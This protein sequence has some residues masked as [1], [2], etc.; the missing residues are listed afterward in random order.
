MKPA[1]L[2]K[3]ICTKVPAKRHFDTYKFEVSNVLS[4]VGTLLA[5]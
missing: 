5:I 4:L 2:T 1:Q 3:F